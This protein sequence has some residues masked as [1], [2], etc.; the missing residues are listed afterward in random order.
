M[1]LIAFFFLDIT[2]SEIA[3]PIFPARYLML[4]ALLF[5]QR[6]NRGHHRFPG[7]DA[8]AAFNQAPAER[9]N[10]RTALL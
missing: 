4:A 9:E 7:C 6:F 2:T 8:C 3:S 10:R 5:Q 1:L